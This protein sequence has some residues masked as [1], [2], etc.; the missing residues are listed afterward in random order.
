MIRRPPRSTQG[1]S[2][3]ASDVYKRQD[4][5]LSNFRKDYRKKVEF[6]PDK[7]FSKP[8]LESRH[9]GF[10][11]HEEQYV[12]LFRERKNSQIVGEA[13]TGYLFSEV[14]A[15]NIYASNPNSKIIIILRDPI[16][17][18][19]SHYLMNLKA[20]STIYNNFLSEVYFDYSKKKKG[21]G[22]SHLY[23]EI[24]LYC[25]QIEKYKKA[26]PNENLKIIILEDMV[27]S[28]ESTI[29]DIFSFFRDTL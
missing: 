4:I 16:E 14:A 24:G 19:F 21:W 7:Y 18:A 11:E 3:A 9:I 25:K 23:V 20:G 27:C 6:D 22:I 10:I 17:R 1:V 29:S 15:E 26:F 28:P 13:S 5:R 8:H 12:S 2:S